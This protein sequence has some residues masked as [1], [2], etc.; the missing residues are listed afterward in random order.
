MDSYNIYNYPFFY[1]FSVNI[2]DY[3]KI[4]DF[5]GSFLNLK[6]FKI[7]KNKITCIVGN[8]GSGKTFILKNILHNSYAK[9]LSS[10]I[11]KDGLIS[12]MLPSV[13]PTLISIYS[14]SIKLDKTIFEYLGLHKYILNVLLNIEINESNKR[15]ELGSSD[16]ASLIFEK[17]N[18]ESFL[19]T[20][21]FAKIHIDH[22]EQFE[23]L[24]LLGFNTVYKCLEPGSKYYN[25]DD[26]DF[27]EGDILYIKVPNISLS[28][29]HSLSK[30]IRALMFKSNVLEFIYINPSGEKEFFTLN[31]KH[32]RANTD[33]LDNFSSSTFNKCIQCNGKGVIKMYNMSEDSMLALTPRQ[34]WSLLDSNS[35]IVGDEACLS[36]FSFYKHKEI[37]EKESLMSVN[38]NIQ[39]EA[40]NGNSNFKGLKQYL[41]DIAV[42]G[43]MLENAYNASCSHCFGT[44]LSA[45]GNVLILGNSLFDILKMSINESLNLIK[46][47]IDINKCKDNI[48]PLNSILNR[49]SSAYS[50]GLK[51]IKLN[52]HINHL[53]Y[54]ER[55]RLEIINL[56]HG[57][58]S[59]VLYLVDEPFSGLDIESS[60]AVYEFLKMISMQ[61][62][63]VVFAETNMYNAKSFSDNI[64]YLNEDNG[65][66]TLSEKENTASVEEENITKLKPIK[67]TTDKC[68]N[69]TTLISGNS[70][71]GK[72]QFINKVVKPFLLKSLKTPTKITTLQQSNLD[73][74]EITSIG[75]FGKLIFKELIMFLC[76]LP[77][78]KIRNIEP[79]HFGS[80]NPLNFICSLCAGRRSIES[81]ILSSTIVTKC[82]SCN[83]SGWSSEAKDISYK[84]HSIIQLQEMNVHQLNNIFKSIA[85]RAKPLLNILSRIGGDKIIPGRLAC[86]VSSGE[87][88]LMKIAET[89]NDAYR[90][91]VEAIIMD[92]PLTGIAKDSQ[93]KIIDEMN[94]LKNKKNVTIFISSHSFFIS[95]ICD[96]NINLNKMVI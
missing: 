19:N 5:C 3:I 16:I 33:S 81:L 69:K 73:N 24:I 93:L 92:E 59:G 22:K 27:K 28:S 79:K 60:K 54:G 77:E 35:H 1:F 71:S 58:L 38:K 46:K 78:S 55:S 88:K 37:N 83:G 14:N 75:W 74:S 65:K 43:K 18:K 76:N 36:W 56:F 63:T 62:N 30:T 95:K 17:A 84:G 91:Y 23:N 7:F 72:T 12:D 45:C 66:Y 68:I 41:T 96:F 44:G 25:S 57:N 15:K 64:L 87:Y 47:Y 32:N 85:F 48:D 34:I 31:T 53:S 10:N 40:L 61:N 94:L 13:Y 42:Q 51:N 70:G 49:L 11:V 82:P 80:R 21:I 2:M 9:Y 89:I 52:T 39:K 8:N 67:Y 86:Q 4:E 29:I 90:R 6:N 50:I 26:I 20:S